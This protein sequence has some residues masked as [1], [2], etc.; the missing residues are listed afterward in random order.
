MCCFYNCG[1]AAAVNGYWLNEKDQ[2]SEVRGQRSEVG[3]Q[4]S[5]VRGQGSGGFRVQ[6]SGF[7]NFSA[8]SFQLQAPSSL[9]AVW[10][11]EPEAKLEH[12]EMRGMELSLE[13]TVQRP[14]LIVESS[15]DA[16]V[17]LNYR[18]YSGTAMGDKWLCVVVKYVED[19]AFVLTAY[20][21]DQPKKGNQVW[22]IK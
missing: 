18:F 2:K 22:P 13:E 1:G 6:D 5:D 21:T 12:P 7:R 19:D 9:R 10:L 3:G 15:T 8:A 16:F 14:T 11:S 20:L 4:R 17:H